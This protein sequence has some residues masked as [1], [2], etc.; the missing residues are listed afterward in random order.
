[1]CTRYIILKKW[2]LTVMTHGV[3]GSVV[4]LG[5]MFWQ[6]TFCFIDHHIKMLRLC[7]S[8]YCLPAFGYF[9]ILAYWEWKYMYNWALR[10]LSRKPRYGL[11]VDGSVFFTRD[12]PCCAIVRMKDSDLYL[13]TPT[14]YTAVRH[15][16][17]VRPLSILLSKMYDTAAVIIWLVP[18]LSTVPSAS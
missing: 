17:V 10:V 16:S 15:S 3:K 8:V 6:L 14:P 1:M 18:D 7:L 9:P 4:L 12:F 13:F 2:R 5:V 11:C